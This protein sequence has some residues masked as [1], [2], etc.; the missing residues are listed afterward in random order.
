MIGLLGT[1][2]DS[3]TGNSELSLTMESIDEYFYLF[4]FDS[5]ST[6]LLQ[7]FPF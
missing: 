4:T 3:G 2:T 7:F 6:T 1:V 5:I